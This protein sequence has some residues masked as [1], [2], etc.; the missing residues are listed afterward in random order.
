MYKDEKVRINFETT[1]LMR[2]LIW[3]RCAD[4]DLTIREYLTELVKKDLK[5][6]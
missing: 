2:D 3:R 1:P 5:T 4:L 6:K